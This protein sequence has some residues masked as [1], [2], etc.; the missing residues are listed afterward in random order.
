MMSWPFT[1]P[2][3]LL[4]LAVFLLWRIGTVILG[5][6]A[7]KRRAL[8][9][10]TFLLGCAS[11]WKVLP[12][13]QRPV[14]N[15]AIRHILTNINGQTTATVFL[16]LFTLF[17]WQLDREGFDSWMTAAALLAF[18]GSALPRGGRRDPRDRG[19]LR[20][21]GPGLAAR[22]QRA[23]KTAPLRRGGRWRFG[24]LYLFYFSAGAASSMTFAPAGNPRQILLFQH[25]LPDRRQERAG[26]TAEPAALYAAAG[27]LH[28]GRRPFLSISEGCLPICAPCRG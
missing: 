23:G 26:R 7:A 2:P 24:L 25:H 28:G 21:R 8:L 16:A 5:G 4:A 20:L 17:F 11:L 3:L 22:L 9:A 27:L 18:A 13:G 1:R 6:S 14:W 15:T 10:A 12:D 19:R